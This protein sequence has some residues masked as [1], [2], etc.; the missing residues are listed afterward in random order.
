MLNKPDKPGFAYKSGFLTVLEL[1]LHCLL[2]VVKL[3]TCKVG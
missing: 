1:L 2:L 3:H